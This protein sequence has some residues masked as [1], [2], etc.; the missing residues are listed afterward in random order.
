V[1]LL[2][3]SQTGIASLDAAAQTH[4]AVSPQQS[5]PTPHWRGVP[6][7]P[8]KK[9]KTTKQLKLGWEGLLEA[10]SRPGSVAQSPV[11][12]SSDHPKGRRL[13]SLPRQLDPVKD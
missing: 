10:P 12:L 5:S 11:P 1:F 3:V 6:F 13:R 7:L 4:G 8:E 2:P 9:K